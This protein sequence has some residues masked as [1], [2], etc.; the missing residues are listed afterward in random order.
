MC[1]RREYHIMPYMRGGQRVKGVRLE[2]D[3]EMGG[4][5]E[6]KLQLFFNCVYLMMGAG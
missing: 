2:E 1:M 3:E 4:G 5:K 6:K